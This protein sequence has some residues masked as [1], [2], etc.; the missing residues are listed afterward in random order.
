MYDYE[1]LILARDEHNDF[2]GVIENE[3]KIE[4]HYNP[5]F[6]FTGDSEAMYKTLTE[7][8][9]K[10]FRFFRDSVHDTAAII[11][12][13]L[14]RFIGLLDVDRI[15]FLAFIADGKSTLQQV[16]EAAKRA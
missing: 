8:E 7:T 6:P 15:I 10:C 13:G 4:E 12:L 5:F 2:F 14:K 9:K 1:E 16:R 3:E 11:N